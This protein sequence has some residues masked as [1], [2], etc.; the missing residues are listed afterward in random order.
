MA[1]SFSLKK[2]FSKIFAHQ[3]ISELADTHGAQLFFEINNQ[4]PRKLAVQLMEDSIKSLDTEKR[5]DILKDLSYIS[6]ITSAHTASLGKKL[7]KEE[8]GKDFEP[9][10]ECNSD[11]DVVLYLYLRHND[12]AE[13]LAFL[14][15]FYSSKSYISY[16]AKKVEKVAMESKLTELSREFTRIANKDDNATE[17][18][19]ENLFL[20]DILYIESKFQ[21]SY[22]IQDKIDNK[23]GEIDKKHVIRKIE[24]VRIAYIPNEE[25]ILLAGNV[26]KQ[27]KMIFLDT[28]LRIVCNGGYEEKVESFNM[29]PLKNLSFDF[30]PFNK[31]TP[32]IKTSVKSVTLSYA[33]GKKKLRIALPASIEYSG[34]QALK[35]TLDELGLAERFNSFDIVNMTFGFMFQNKEKQDKSV[36]V[37]CSISPNRA[38][39]C[40]LFEYERY[41]KSILKNAGIYEGWKVVENS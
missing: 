34:L 7:F 3:L 1:Q 15:P 23:T 17:Q 24:N 27:Q 11:Y 30:I 41:T 35:E 16:E 39:L 12:I 4:T 6:S 37:S 38:T 8:T 28:F 13:K 21:G 9:E 31:G 33:E 32:F 2:Y 26:S 18:E 25:V 10:I 5:L 14:F 29:D 19:M 36:N 22:N 40:P 20:N